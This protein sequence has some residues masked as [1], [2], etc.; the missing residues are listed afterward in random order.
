MKREIKFRGKRTKTEKFVYGYYMYTFDICYNSQGYYDVPPRLHYI[1]DATGNFYEVDPETVG[2]YIN[3][4]DTSG[5]EIYEGDY[6]IEGG[7]YF[8]A[9]YQDGELG[10]ITHEPGFSPD[11]DTCVNWHNFTV[12][13][14][15]WDNPDLLEGG[16]E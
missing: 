9:Q 14:N 3:K 16:Y 7:V 8:I 13:G 4:K 12:C 11:F 15:R 1:F 6:D 10:M 5:K 2:Q